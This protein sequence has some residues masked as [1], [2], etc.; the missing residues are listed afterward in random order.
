MRSDRRR[1]RA[2]SPLL[3]AE[4][5]LDSERERSG[6]AAVILWEGSEPLATSVA[7]EADR[8][9][10]TAVAREAERDGSEPGRDVYVH[11]VTVGG[12]TLLLAS[13]DARLPSVR[14]AE[15][16]LARILA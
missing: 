12:R 8:A 10:F 14:R 2:H 3:A 11:R 5:Y 4:Y 15:A 7:R 13:V 9:M 6:A 1:R 16:A